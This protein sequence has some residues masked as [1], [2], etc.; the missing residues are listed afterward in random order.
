MGNKLYHGAAWY[1][2]L[3]QEDVLKADIEWMKKAGINVVR[4][5]EFAWSNM[6]PQ[7][8]EID[9]SFFVRIVGLLYDNGIETVM[10]TPTPTPP[11]WFTD[12]HPER[13]YVNEQLQ[14][15][16]HGSRQHACTNHPYFREKAAIITEHIA[17]AMGR[18]P[19]LIG[20]Q[21]DNEFKAHV[22]ECM[23]ATCL[24]QWHQWLERRYGTIERLNDT[25]G[26]QIWSEYYHRFDQV[27][28]PG[29]A[30]FLHN[31]SLKTMYQLFSM[32]SIAQFADEQAAIIRQYSDAGI[33]HNS[34]V[35][36]SVDN[37][38]LFQGLDF[39]SFDTYA[40]YDNLP[41][42]LINN[43]LFRNFKR[44]RDY[45]I[46]ETSPSYAASLESY[47]KPHPNGY[48]KAEAVAAYALGAEA[49]CYWLW[50]Q[51]RAGC[52]QPHGSVLSAW[53]KPTVGYMNVLEVEQAR[54]AIEATILSTRPAQAEVAMTYSD[55]AK[56]FLKTEPHRKL[57]HRGL[58]T[59]FYARLLHVGVHR[60]VVPEGAA[61]D[62]YKLLFTPLLPYV[63]PDYI[64]RATKLAEDGGVWVIGPLTGG[65]TES[66]T[67]HTTSALGELEE[68]AGVE[69]AF[70]YPMDDSGAIGSA[71]GHTAPLSLWSSVYELKGASAVGTIE[72]GLSPGLAFVTEK[73]C[74]KGKIVMLGSMPAGE[75]G[76]RML[77]AL[78]IHYA[79]EAGVTLRTDVTPGTIVAPR[80]GDGFDVWV[81]VNMDGKGGS[82]TLPAG[83]V[84]VLTQELI[85]PGSKLAVGKYEY[86]MIRI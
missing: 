50:R 74:G 75:E 34:S 72:G 82:V 6:E 48:L 41:A 86:R 80:R 44:G 26:T 15:M 40:T 4:I 67:V 70:T 33:T 66:H 76:Q 49:F 29:P 79:D 21:L 18:L 68:L 36:F 27:P 83:G 53:G 32:E 85:A 57:N 10:C 78:I 71:F 56:A 11:I 25:W 31:S 7:E 13:M 30:P 38:R 62:G 17:R 37:E 54:Q 61:L 64:Q 5:G 47:A 52:E 8:G 22:S 69:A 42:Y 24:T 60:D 43:D 20:W 28:Q 23:C 58:V 2:E 45:W 77:D 51:Q 39:A 59:D 9:L 73:R 84:D 14:T 81:V 16:G 35:A 46:M 3:W 12:G 65:R 19:G 55:R 63:S 1:P